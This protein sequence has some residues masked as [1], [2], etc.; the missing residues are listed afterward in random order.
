[1]WKAL[2]KLVEKWAYRCKHNWIKE[3]TQEVYDSGKSNS[4][5]PKKII[6]TYVCDKCLKYKQISQYNKL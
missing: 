5:L 6:R 3:N 4:E 2:I 1:M